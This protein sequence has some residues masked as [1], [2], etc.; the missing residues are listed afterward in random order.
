MRS[1][2]ITYRTLEAAEGGSRMVI[3]TKSFASTASSGDGTTSDSKPQ[4]FSAGLNTDGS[5]VRVWGGGQQI[6]VPKAEVLEIESE[7]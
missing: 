3:K 7:E 4:S 2:K 1:V 6:I 5:L